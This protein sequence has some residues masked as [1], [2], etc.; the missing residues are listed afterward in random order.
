MKYD[1]DAALNQ[2][3][4]DLVEAQDE[5]RH[6][7]ARLAEIEAERDGWER[8][9]DAAVEEW[10]RASARLAAVLALCD[11]EDPEMTF[12]EWQSKVRAAAAGD[13]AGLCGPECSPVHVCDDPA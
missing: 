6:L 8:E 5:R 10:R 2:L 1:P 12:P 11:D 13:R 9:H 7:R 3:V 4:R